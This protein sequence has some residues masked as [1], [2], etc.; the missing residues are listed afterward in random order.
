MAETL[1]KKGATIVGNTGSVRGKLI[2]SRYLRL[3]PE[4][5]EEFR[6]WAREIVGN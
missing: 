6:K 5:L 1:E 4:D 3:H 2:I